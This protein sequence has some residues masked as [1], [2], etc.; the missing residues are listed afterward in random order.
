MM[1]EEHNDSLSPPF[2]HDFGFVLPHSS[3]SGNFPIKKV[4]IFVFGGFSKSPIQRA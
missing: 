1:H 3:E 4:W 2:P